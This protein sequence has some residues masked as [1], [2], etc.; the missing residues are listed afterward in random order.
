MICTRMA[1][2]LDL[3][4]TN[5][6]KQIASQ[7]SGRSEGELSEEKNGGSEGQRYRK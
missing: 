2:D 7:E 6:V 5:I 3:I 4:L 1:N